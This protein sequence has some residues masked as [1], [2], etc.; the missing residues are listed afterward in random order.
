LFIPPLPLIFKK[1]A[2][3]MPML[4]LTKN[5]DVDVTIGKRCWC[6]ELNPPPTFSNLETLGVEPATENSK[7]ETAGN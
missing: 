3:F 7:L 2:R 6:L 1:A 4:R 5:I